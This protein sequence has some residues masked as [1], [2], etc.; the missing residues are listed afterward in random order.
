MADSKSDYEVGPGRP[1]LHT[2]FKE[3]QS[4]NPGGSPSPGHSR[5][6]DAVKPE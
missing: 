5:A 4:G 6:P 1:L 2:R 3:G